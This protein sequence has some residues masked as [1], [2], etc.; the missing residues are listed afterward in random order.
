MDSQWD[1]QRV[2]HSERRYRQTQTSKIEGDAWRGWTD[3]RTEFKKVQN[4]T[5]NIR[6]MKKD[7]RMKRFQD[8][9]P[10]N[11]H[12]GREGRKDMSDGRSGEL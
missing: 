1:V 4:Q 12:N 2:R 10:E 6:K 7:R 5:K 8:G 11:Q 9:S 3:L